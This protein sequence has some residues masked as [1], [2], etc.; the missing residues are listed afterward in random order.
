MGSDFSKNNNTIS[1]TNVL[2]LCELLVSKASK[3]RQTASAFVDANQD[4][5]NNG[6]FFRF[7]IDNNLDYIKLDDAGLLTR[8][9][10][11]AAVYLDDRFVGKQIGE[12]EKRLL[13]DRFLPLH[14]AISVLHAAICSLLHTKLN[15]HYVP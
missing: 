11:T 7:K 1:S 10:M 13:Q 9:E 5:V 6:A 15:L 8:V 14:H 4:M 3:T 2:R 12:R